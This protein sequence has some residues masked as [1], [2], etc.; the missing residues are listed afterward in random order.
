MRAFWSYFAKILFVFVIIESWFLYDFF[1]K[2]EQLL[3]E[4]IQLE[5]ELLATKESLLL[6]ETKITELE[7]KSLEG[8]LKQSNEAMVTAWE[9]LSDTVERELYKARASVH[10]LTKPK[11]KEQEKKTLVVEEVETIDKEQKSSNAPEK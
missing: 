3:A 6:T 5:R 2:N 9:T 4:N 11:E 1:Q 10:E 8:M 7:N